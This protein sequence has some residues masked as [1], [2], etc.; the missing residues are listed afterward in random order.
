MSEKIEE[1]FSQGKNWHG[2]RRFRRHRL[3]RVRQESY[4]I[5]WAVNLK[6]RAKL[7]SPER[8]TA[9]AA[10]NPAVNILSVAMKMIP[11]FPLSAS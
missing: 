6:R 4:L 7:L 3:A 10:G 8:R 11:S 1:P 5:G 2:L 9:E